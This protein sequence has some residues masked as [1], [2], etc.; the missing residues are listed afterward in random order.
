MEMKAWII[1]HVKQSHK[2]P[3]MRP[4]SE[5]AVGGEL[6]PA[7]GSAKGVSEGFTCRYCDNQTTSKDE[8]CYNCKSE[9]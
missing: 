4:A 9:H 1:D 6:L 7:E 3:V 5:S 8:V 2:L